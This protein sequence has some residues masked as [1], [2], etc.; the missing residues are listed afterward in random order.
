MTFLVLS[1]VKKYGFLKKSGG[2]NRS[3]SVEFN[4]MMNCTLVTYIR[5]L[6]IL[7]VI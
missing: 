4:S 5:A 1:E 6:N 2:A 7:S 3:I